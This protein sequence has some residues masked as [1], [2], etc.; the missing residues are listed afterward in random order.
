MLKS[1]CIKS[2]L[3]TQIKLITQLNL[4]PSLTNKG[5]GALSS[6]GSLLVSL[7]GRQS[8]SLV[9]LSFCGSVITMTH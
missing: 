1:I 8:D 5:L 2:F 3:G 7:L 6:H 4:N 9:S